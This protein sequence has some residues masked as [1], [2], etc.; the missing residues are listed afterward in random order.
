MDNKPKFGLG[1]QPGQKPKLAESAASKD[2]P[3]QAFGIN[4]KPNTATPQGPKF[5][6]EAA[7][8]HVVKGRPVQAYF[9]HATDKVLDHPIR[10]RRGRLAT[11]DGHGVAVDAVGDQLDLVS[12]HRHHSAID[13]P[14]AGQAK[15]VR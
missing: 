8:K 15:H 11:R 13:R 14:K 9:Y 5:G 7:Q 6:T 1:A 10:I 12:V 2:Q 4:A 3:K